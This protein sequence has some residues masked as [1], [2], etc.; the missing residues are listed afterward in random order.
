M[1]AGGLI[2]ARL[3]RLGA[4][5]FPI[6]PP[7]V[8]LANVLQIQR[9]PLQCPPGQGSEGPDGIVVL[10]G[11]ALIAHRGGQPHDGIQQPDD[12][13][14]IGGEGRQKLLKHGV[15]LN[16]P[17]P[18]DFKVVPRH[19]PGGHQPP[20]VQLVQG[21][22]I[23]VAPRRLLLQHPGEQGPGL[24]PLEAVEVFRLAVQGRA[25]Q[26]LLRH[27]QGIAQGLRQIHHPLH[28]VGPVV[29]GD[30]GDGLPR[31]GG[32]GLRIGQGLR[33]SGGAARQQDQGQDRRPK[34]FHSF[35]KT[36]LKKDGAVTAPSFPLKVP[37]PPG[38]ARR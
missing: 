12:I 15:H 36:S 38:S 17:A 31:L 21:E 20:G 32:G 16:G 8:T 27:G 33:P 18:G 7:P 29:Q 10:Q 14:F 11:P 35:H 37:G 6:G 28:V 34:A 30:I 23:A 25:V 3:L 19:R 26:D 13:V 5:V 2:V 4:E 24:P 9:V 22:N 1:P